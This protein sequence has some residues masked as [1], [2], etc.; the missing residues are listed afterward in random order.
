MIKKGLTY[1]II[2]TLALYGLRSLHYYGLLKQTTGY[3][4]TYKTAFLNENKFDVIFLGSSRVQ[5]HYNTKLFDSINHTNSFNLS[6]AGATPKIAFHALKVYLSKSKAPQTIIYDVD[7]HNLNNE[8]WEI[9]DFNNY[10]PF[11]SDQTF[12]TEFSK[13]D[14]RMNW[15]YYN[16]FY[17]WPYTGIKNLSTGLH[18][19]FNKKNRTD[20]LFYKG[21]FMEKLKPQLNFI[22]TKPANIQINKIEKQ[23]LDS[24]FIFTQKNNIQLYLM[25]SPMFAG[26]KLDVAN[27]T[28]L[29]E[30]VSNLAQAHGSVY[31]DLSSLPFCDQRKLFVDHF[32]MNYT[33]SCLF[34]LKMSELYRNILVKKALKP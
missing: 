25:S 31:F 1:F 23:Y 30:Q 16:A 27:K 29:I 33:G 22:S 24:L 15:F 19:L 6:M 10:F 17:S 2:V 21:Y 12:R 28:E 20:D 11:L 8:S 7:F 34:T 18:G 14:K 5:M 26:G 3:Y 13:V 32:H 9:K 4:Q